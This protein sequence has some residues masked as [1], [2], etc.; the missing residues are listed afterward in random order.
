[1]P[2]LTFIC[3]RMPVCNLHPRRSNSVHSFSVE[4][5]AAVGVLCVCVELS[6]ALDSNNRWDRSS[7]FENRHIRKKCLQTVT[8][9]L[10]ETIKY[11][12]ITWF[13]EEWRSGWLHSAVFPLLSAVRHFQCASAFCR[14]SIVTV[15]PAADQYVGLTSRCWGFTRSMAFISNTNSHT[16]RDTYIHTHTQAQRHSQLCFWNDTHT[17]CC[18]PD[19]LAFLDQTHTQWIECVW[20]ELC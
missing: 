5:T 4:E 1:M 14:C 18:S 19:R 6:T 17:S 7:G 11:T 10:T 9:S 2:L 20:A 3:P 12:V 16:Q 15:L 13:R 8:H